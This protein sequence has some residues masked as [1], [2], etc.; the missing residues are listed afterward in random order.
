[1]ELNDAAPMERIFLSN[2]MD[3][4]IFYILLGV[5]SLII[6]DDITTVFIQIYQAGSSEAEPIQKTYG[7]LCPEGHYCNIG[8]SEPNK[9]PPGT[10]RP[11]LGA[12]NISHCLDCPPGSFCQGYGNK[13]ISGIAN[14]QSLFFKF[15]MSRICLLAY[16]AMIF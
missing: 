6:P 4:K 16:R 9:C 13:E 1:M 7:D 15:G 3:M 2:I 12:K 10:Y 11:S 5:L 14:K 8:T